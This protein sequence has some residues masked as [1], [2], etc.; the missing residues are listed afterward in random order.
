MRRPAGHMVKGGA[1]MGL[2]LHINIQKGEFLRTAE[3]LADC[4]IAN[5][6]PDHV[7]Y[8]NFKGPRD[9]KNGK[10]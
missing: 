5:R 10:R 1:F 7:P 9:T 6:P 4:Y 2:L 8:W 3:K